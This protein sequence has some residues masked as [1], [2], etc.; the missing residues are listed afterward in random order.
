M[1]LL[2]TLLFIGLFALI[3]TGL[4]RLLTPP[5]GKDVFVDGSSTVAPIT[6][7]AAAQFQRYRSD[8]R[9]SVGISGTSGGFRRFLAHETNINDASRPIK[10][11]EIEKAQEEGIEYIELIVAL[12][13]VTVAVSRHTQ[14]F[15]GKA[16]CLTIGELELLWAREAEGFITRWSQLGSRFAD[17]PIALSGAAETSGTFDFFTSAVAGDEGDTRA[18]YF[19][20]EEDQLLAEQTGQNPYALT[21]FGFAY[22][23]HNQQLVQAVAVDPRRELIDAPQAVLEEINR[24][25]AQ[26]G[27]PPLRNGGGRCQGIPPTLDTIQ[28]FLYRPLSRPL[29]LYVNAQSA[30][31]E[32]VAAFVDFYASEEVIGSE[33]LMQDVSYIVL[34]EELQEASRAC[35]EER[36]K[37]T[38]F[39]GRITGFSPE[40]LL[41]TYLAHCGL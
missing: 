21:Y 3:L 12:D 8:V 23:V 16:P 1:K 29:F 7:A 13:G 31:R 22:F 11:A 15:Q 38:A 39:G 9:V 5:T 20:T 41:D 17:A 19:G 32:A 4:A 14:I 36:I 28:S 18:D 40:E 37:G 2:R 33:D 27:K 6:Q 30:Q 35:W 24:R 25:R 10:P 34:G 26:H